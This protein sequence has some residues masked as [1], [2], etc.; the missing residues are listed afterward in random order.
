MIYQELKLEK[1]KI[2]ALYE[3]NHWTNYTK[4]KDSLFQGIKQSLYAY[5]AYDEDQLVGL[6]RVVGDGTTIVYIQDLLVLPEYQR[7]GIGTTL[8]QHIL[9]KYKNVRQIVL[10][11]DLTKQQQAF[12]ESIGFVK[13]ES[14]PLQGYY[15]K[16]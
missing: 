3:A 14:I 5:A 16:K 4:D 2:L 13:Y 15:Y 6:I 8:M 10:S 11:T 12:Y 7:Q 1:N 9:D